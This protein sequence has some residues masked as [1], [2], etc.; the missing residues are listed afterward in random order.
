MAAYLNSNDT[1]DLVAV[2]SGGW[3]YRWKL[4]PEIL[5]DSLFWPMTGYD[6]GRSF[7]Y[8]G[9]Q[10][11]M[12][13]TESEPITFHSYP[14][15]SNGAGE[16]HFKYKFSGPATK[17]RLDIFTITGYSVYSTTSMGAPPANLTGSYPDWNELV[18]SLDRFGPGLY[19]CRLEATIGGT[20]HSKF[21]KMAVIK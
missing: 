15:P 5:P 12:L 14:N 3:V 21:W 7:A 10:L 1:I 2:S 13:T 9:R 11:S 19:R 8:G 4:P 17:V 16:V 18:V 6:R 20:K